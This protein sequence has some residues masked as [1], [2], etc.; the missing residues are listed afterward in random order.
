MMSHSVT[1]TRTQLL[2]AQCA[3]QAPCAP[4]GGP[5]ISNS[6]PVAVQRYTQSQILVACVA[7]PVFSLG[8]GGTSVA[9]P[10]SAADRTNTANMVTRFMSQSPDEEFAVLFNSDPDMLGELSA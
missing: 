4:W 3:T 1:D 10:A 2:P 7:S 6:S 8:S 5:I 9:Q